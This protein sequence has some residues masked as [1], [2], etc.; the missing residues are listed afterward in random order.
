[1]K[2]KK[3]YATLGVEQ[4]A[5]KEAIK[6]ARTRKVKETHPDM[7][8]GSQ[9]AFNEVQH[10]YKVLSDPAAR[11]RYD[12]TGAEEAPAQD[13]A[14]QQA[15]SHIAAVIRSLLEAAFDL[16]GVNLPEEIA[17][18]LERARRSALAHIDARKKVV[19]RATNAQM[20]VT[21]HG[22]NALAAVLQ[23]AAGESSRIIEREEK[24]LASIERA[25]EIVQS[26][27]FDVDPVAAARNSGVRS[28]GRY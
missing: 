6:R 16:N 4:D 11:E 19:A 22:E 21:S 27:A 18:H 26:H 1:M 24:H 7:P 17:T 3:L 25:L 12:A 23:Y 15:H 9:A 13:A 2:C 14:E 20:R 28:G 10:A 5:S 8:T